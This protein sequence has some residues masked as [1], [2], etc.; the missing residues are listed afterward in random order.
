MVDKR[1]DYSFYRDLL[2]SLHGIFFS[3][4]SVAGS[5]YVFST[6]HLPF[7][8][9]PERIPDMV[10][11]RHILSLL[12]P[13]LI[14]NSDCRM[15]NRGSEHPFTLLRTVQDSQNLSSSRWQVG[16]FHLTKNTD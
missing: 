14:R 2:G 16:S 7:R 1:I 6:L 10:L 12:T 9:L 15:M 3:M 5:M 8:S 11:P 4:H 13:D